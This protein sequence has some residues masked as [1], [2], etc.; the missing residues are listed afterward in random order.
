MVV[1]VGYCAEQKGFAFQIAYYM[2]I[3]RYSGKQNHTVFGQL[4]RSSHIVY[5]IWQS[6]TYFGKENSLIRQR[7]QPI[8]KIFSVRLF[9]RRTFGYDYA[10]CPFVASAIFPEQAEWQYP[11]FEKRAIV[12]G[13]QY[14][15][16]PS[17]VSVLVSII[18]QNE[19]YVR[20]FA[21]YDFNSPVPI[22]ANGEK[23]I[24]KLLSHLQRFVAEVLC[25]TMRLDK[26]V[27]LRLSA[28]SA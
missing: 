26:P 6:V 23:N 22:F 28:V 7:F 19:V 3:I 25:P 4:D 11:V 12:L 1:V 9:K 15:E 16:I 10:V 2:G 24:G 18:E 13:Q 20:V 17:R 5:M 14:I 8:Y 27:A 21:L